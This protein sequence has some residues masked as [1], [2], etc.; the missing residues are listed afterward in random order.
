MGIFVQVR[1]DDVLAA[2][3]ANDPQAAA[4]MVTAKKPVVKFVPKS[5]SLFGEHKNLTSRAS[6]TA[7]SLLMHAARLAAVSSL[8]HERKSCTCFRGSRIREY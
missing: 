8:Q 2:N 3:T 4:A 1:P 6:S 7:L 5:V